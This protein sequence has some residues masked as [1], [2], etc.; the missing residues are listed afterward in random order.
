MCMRRHA[1]VS[2]ALLIG[3]ACGGHPDNPRASTAPSASQNVTAP[4][5]AVDHGAVVNRQ[6]AFLVRLASVRAAGVFTIGGR[7]EKARSGEQLIV[8]RLRVTNTGKQPGQL[9][10][11]NSDPVTLVDANGRSYT[12]AVSWASG[13]TIAPG[14]SRVEPYVFH[15][16]VGITP[17]TVTVGLVD[18]DGTPSTVSLI[19][20]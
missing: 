10:F 5:A 6:T 7:E 4:P 18:V 13:A 16:P 8:V 17:A 11:G 12:T 19:V 15:V 20:P 9:E 1:I 3:A 2:A 14:L